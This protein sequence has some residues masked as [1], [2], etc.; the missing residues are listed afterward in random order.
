MNCKI[1]PGVTI[2]KGSFLLPGTVLLENVEPMRIVAGDP[3]KLM[4]LP[5]LQQP[6]KKENMRK[7]GNEVLNGYCQWSNEYKE[8]DWQVING[9]LR[10]KHRSRYYEITLGSSGDIILITQEGTGGKEMYFN[11]TDL[12]TDE[13]KHPVK[14]KLEEYLRLYYGLIFLSNPVG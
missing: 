9:S 11:L 4:K 8:T 6:V 3:G 10:I 14:Q 12:S 7:F 5:I 2:E 13:T 1:G